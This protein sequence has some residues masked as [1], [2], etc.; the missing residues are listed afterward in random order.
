MS[1]T[2]YE[3]LTRSCLDLQDDLETSTLVKIL[4]DQNTVNEEISAIQK[5]KF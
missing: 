4:N 1:H 3:G 5:C 2:S